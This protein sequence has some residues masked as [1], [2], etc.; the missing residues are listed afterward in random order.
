LT[1]GCTLLRLGRG[2]PEKSSV[3]SALLDKQIQLQRFADDF[4]A[5]GGQALDETAERLGT[6]SGREQI[7]RVKLLLGSSVIAVVSGPN[8]NANLLDI[9]S[10]TVLT[11]MSVQNYWMKTTNGV[12]FQPALDASR[13]L[14]TNVWDLADRFLQPAQVN[15]LRQGIEQWYARTHE[16]RTA[17]FARP[18]AFA[19]MVRTAQEKGGTSVFSLVNVDPMAG[20]EPAVREVT[21][22]RLFA[23]RAMYTA[24]RLPFVLRLQVEMLT[25]DVTEQPAV[26]LA[27][28]NSTQLSDSA[29]RI[30][31]AAESL[32]QSITQF[33][34]RLA[35]ERKE[36]LEALDVQ[37]GKLRELTTGVNQALVSGEKFSGSL[38]ITIT[39]I[40][41]LMRLGGAGEPKTNTETNAAP[42]NILD[43][44]R[45]ADEI[46]K[47]AKDANALVNSI[48]QTVPGIE[49]L[50][51]QADAEANNI[52]NHSFWIGLA[53]IAVL[54]IG[55]VLAGLLYTFLAQKLRTHLINRQ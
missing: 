9:V 31:G 7:L 21:Q 27:L 26:R 18:H 29:Q 47:M 42:F 3:Q 33:P 35:A 6:D 17:F 19:S 54:L 49:R 52:V 25:Y 43:Y 5:R 45:A 51:Q 20:L 4:L 14:E 30:S 12:A 22:S 34:D 36:V 24:Q 13:V 15:E 2:E 38:N 16:V 37:E 53:L 44:A 39:N 48:N 55:S 46:D 11:R 50:S 28:T 40:Q 23:E 32:S 41:G 8:P 1:A 10:L